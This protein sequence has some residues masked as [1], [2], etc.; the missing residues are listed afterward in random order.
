MV[1]ITIRG[2]E[3]C[4]K[5]AVLQKV[6]NTCLRK[7][8]LILSSQ[9]QGCG[10]IIQFFQMSIRLGHKPLI[11]NMDCLNFVTKLSSIAPPL[12]KLKGE[13][14]LFVV[15]F[16][17]TRFFFSPQRED[18]TLCAEIALQVYP[19]YSSNKL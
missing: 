13:T 4:W 10:L 6:V 7:E 1:Y 2:C 19:V 11:G 15:S 12:K 8:V 18:Q 3:I 16:L 17:V 9:C 14:L 5:A